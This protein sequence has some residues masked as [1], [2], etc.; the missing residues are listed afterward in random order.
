MGVFSSSGRVHGQSSW[1][2]LLAEV[3]SIKTEL[4]SRYTAQTSCSQRDNVFV[5]GRPHKEPV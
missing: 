3:E 4:D 5:H 2:V 1:S